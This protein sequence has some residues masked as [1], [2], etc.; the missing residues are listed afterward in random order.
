MS[1]PA[2]Y[3]IVS[4]YREQAEQLADMDLDEQTFKDSLESIQWPVEEKARAVAAVIGNMVAANDM[5][6]DFIKRK[7][8]QLKA[9]QAREDHLREYLLRNML[10]CEITEIK[11]NDGSLTIK[12]KNNPPSVIVDSLVEIPWEY[13][14][15]KPPPPAEP[16]KVAIKEALKAGINVPGAHLESKVSVSIK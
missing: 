9:M 7:Q 15:E 10:D 5:L 6:A 12:V 16:D 1:L 13:M 4:E 11:S 2:L 14:R 8:A 3:S